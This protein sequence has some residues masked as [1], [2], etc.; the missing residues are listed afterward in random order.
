M[1]VGVAKTGCYTGPNG[2]NATVLGI[3]VF[4]LEFACQVRVTLSNYGSRRRL[5]T[6][7]MWCVTNVIRTS[8]VCSTPYS[9]ARSWG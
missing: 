3:T 6:L 9:K 7:F 8:L 2:P 1:F 5:G 4:E